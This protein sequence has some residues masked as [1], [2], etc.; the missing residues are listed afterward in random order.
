MR[1]LL[2]ATILKETEKAALVD[3]TLDSATGQRGAKVWFPKS[4]I[5]IIPGGSVHVS[6][7]ILEQKE[8]ELGGRS[9]VVIVTAN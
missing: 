4:Q 7:W 5:R 8:R 1:K 9:W 2:D 6:E 3:V